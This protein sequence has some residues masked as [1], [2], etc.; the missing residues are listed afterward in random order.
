MYVLDAANLL[1]HN[2]DGHSDLPVP[3]MVSHAHLTDGRPAPELFHRIRYLRI[4][5]DLGTTWLIN[6]AK[7]VYRSK[8]NFPSSGYYLVLILPLFVLHLPSAP[9]DYIIKNLLPS[10]RRKQGPYSYLVHIHHYSKSFYNSNSHIL[11]HL[12]FHQNWPVLENTERW[13]KN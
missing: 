1:P 4:K 13:R 7:S 3:L 2:I 9:D 11:M 12:E 5:P 10:F 8:L 6:G